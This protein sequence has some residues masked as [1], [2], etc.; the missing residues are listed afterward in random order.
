MRFKNAK[1]RFKLREKLILI[2]LST[3]LVSISI[4]VYLNLEDFIRVYKESIKR[5][6]F[7]EATG[8][9]HLIED[10]T[11]LG[12]SLGELKG[13]SEECRKVV[14]A[15]PYARYCF[16]MGDSGEVYYHNLS[17]KVG[18]IYR[19]A[20]THAALKADVELVQYSAIN[21]KEFIYDFSEPIKDIS[22]KQVGVI[23]IGVLSTIIDKEV[24][25][26]IKRA[27]WLGIF[28]ITIACL[29]VFFLFNYNIL[30]PIR[31][32]MSGVIRFGKGDFDSK[33][34]LKTK[35]EL[36]ELADAFNKMAYNL[37][38]S[39]VSI[40][41]LEESQRRFQDIAES[42]SDWIWETD[43]HGRYTY[44][45]PEVEKVIGYKA[46][47]ILGKY[48]YD[49]FHPDLR[50]S[51]KQSSFAQF[52]QKKAFKN[53]LNQ[54]IDRNGKT[55]ITETSGVS[56]L[57]KDGQLSGFRGVDRNITER[58]RAEEALH[59][60][61]RRLLT[62]MSNL[63]GLAYRGRNDRRRSMEF[64]S[65][66][67]SD[68]TGYHSVEFMDKA[69]VTYGEIVHPDD[70]KYVWNEIQAAV[71]GRRFYRMIY[72]IRTAKGEE[73]WVW[74]Q[75]RGIFSG[76][77]G[78]DLLA[79]EGFISDITE[80]K[81]SEELLVQSKKQAEVANRA[82]S[83]FLANM[84]H[85]IRTPMNAI[86]GFTGL[87]ADTSLD[88]AQKDFVE[89]I[90]DSGQLLLSL[91]NNILDISKVEAGE[92]RLEK[93]NFDLE[94]LIKSVIKMTSMRLQGKDVELRYSIDQNTPA[95]FLGDPTRIRQIVMNLIVNAIKFTEQGEVAV[96]IGLE[97]P[98]SG[99]TKDNI[100]TLFVSVKD[101]GIGIPKE[102]QEKIFEAF[103]QVDTST[104]RKYGGTGLGLTISKAL[105]EMMGGKIRVVSEAGKGSEF[106]F[107]LKLQKAVPIVPEAKPIAGQSGTMPK[108][109]ELSCQGLNILVVEDNMVNQ[110]LLNL[111]LN[112]FGCKVDIASN[113]EIAVSKV[114][115][116]PY[117]LVLMDLQM[118]VMGGFEAT[119]IIRASINRTLPI[120]A[121]TAAA[122]KEDEEKCFSCGM[123]D[124]ITKPVEINRLKEKIIKWTK[125]G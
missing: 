74:E 102:K 55:V 43:L 30:R 50:E 60:S 83:E 100:E 115:T 99:E 118:P 79:L 117:D 82:K 17:E 49:F 42:T 114:K 2:A 22:G 6:V 119:E 93:I 5:R 113:G 40:E 54:K 28:F 78:G 87:L 58:K 101:T 103:E 77:G 33:I 98:L 36:G 121:L 16:V 53:L 105:V 112:N 15:I 66:G 39:T 116:N 81:R 96:S 62:L 13:L 56:V 37:R 61:Q 7:V 45:S 80:Q 35:D 91:I 21:S 52:I 111:V 94:D 106:I 73:K 18:D 108:L 92:M 59:E 89:T 71:K 3:I 48:F 68:L 11:E 14:K 109:E 95:N 85:E 12:L 88:A 31:N 51:L 107:T 24:T 110:K 67:C 32:L 41:V 34:E 90:R 20:I 63:S 46:E 125:K 97:Q 124:F 104:T 75:G 19:D 29:G 84:S 38:E 25:R 9:K 122:M 57:N 72:R 123:N 65:E 64:V 69:K 10:V 8:L 1:I 120:I 44:S 70:Q 76:L 47:E 4:I 27:L 86:I 26:M 23:R